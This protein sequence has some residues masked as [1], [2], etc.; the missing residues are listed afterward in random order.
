MN[1]TPA[2]LAAALDSTNLRLDASAADIVALCRE[3]AAHRFACVMIYPGSVALAAKELAGT[4]LKIGTVIGF[5]SGRFST[6]AKAAEIDAMHAAG[7]HEVDIVMN[8]AALRDGDIQLVDTELRSL[9]QRAHANGQLVKII[10][11]TCY[12]DDTQRLASLRLCEDAGVEFIKT[13]TGFG[14]AG[15]QAEHLAV[16]AAARRGPI[17]IKASGGIKTLADARKMMAA[18]ATR[19]GTSSAAAIVAELTGGAA[20]SA[21]GY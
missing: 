3:A 19:L 4:G 5:P 7:A 2:Q 17:Q 16:W 1:L 21:G 11:E 10:V 9:T 18:G 14:S 20:A 12:L 13:S 15:A 8:Y 6:A